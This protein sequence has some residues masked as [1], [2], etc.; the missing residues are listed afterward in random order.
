MFYINTFYQKIKAPFSTSYEIAINFANL[1]KNTSLKMPLWK[2]QLISAL[3]ITALELI[4]GLILN[5]G[6]GFYMFLSFTWVW[7][8]YNMR[9]NT[10][11]LS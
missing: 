4:F 3:I 6:L 8:Y 7:F 10:W 9:H 11:L 1:I 2:Q 5:I